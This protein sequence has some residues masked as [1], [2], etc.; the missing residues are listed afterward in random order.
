MCI[1]PHLATPPPCTQFVCD[2]TKKNP[3]GKCLNETHVCDGYADCIDATDES[4]E[5]CSYTTTSLTST[6]TTIRT[7]EGPSGM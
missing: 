7:T 5:R 4:N 2:V 6:S 1:C 3:V